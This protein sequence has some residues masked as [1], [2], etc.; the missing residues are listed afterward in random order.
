M[1]GTQF[2]PGGHSV[3]WRADQT[4]LYSPRS[5]PCYIHFM[6]EPS[7]Q[8]QSFGPQAD[9]IAK[10][11]L[12]S[13]DVHEA[14]SARNTR[15]TAPL[16]MDD[17][18]TPAWADP[19]MIMKDTIK[20]ET[21]RAPSSV[22][23]STSDTCICEDLHSRGVIVLAAVYG[24]ITIRK[25]DGALDVRL[26]VRNKVYETLAFYFSMTCPLDWLGSWVDGTNTFPSDPAYKSL[27]K[28]LSKEMK[29]RKRTDS[30]TL[31]TSEKLFLQDF[32]A[33]DA[34][35][36]DL[37]LSQVSPFFLSVATAR[38]SFSEETV[39]SLEGDYRSSWDRILAIA[40]SKPGDALGCSNLSDCPVALPK[41]S[42]KTVPDWCELFAL[43][44]DVLLD[45]GNARGS[46]G[47]PRCMG[48]FT[49]AA[50][51]LVD[52]HHNGESAFPLRQHPDM[53]DSFIS[54]T[55][56]VTGDAE[57]GGHFTPEGPFFSPINNS[58]SDDSVTTLAVLHRQSSQTKDQVL[59]Q[60]CLCMVSLLS[61]LRSAGLS[62][63]PVFGVVIDQ[64][65]CTLLA[66]MQ[67]EE[68]ASCSY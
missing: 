2:V 49:D 54:A 13:V 65:E 67:D 17:G 1:S 25:F 22:L 16:R 44:L 41:I 42:N 53:N 37:F 18:Q 9:I 57:H 59:D 39:P 36:F 51:H 52:F 26:R 35:G 40:C 60:C 31:S 68:T 11:A 43:H 4:T 62:G 21:L 29:A 61:S 7:D 56:L 28:K 46:D 12:S 50:F 32:Q 10:S 5:N 66:A 19:S 55:L 33:D 63:T 48:Y 30:A 15:S 34:I 3:S 24:E 23:S 45:H 58:T 38:S 20:E 47:P 14:D 64:T 6:K 27:Q 8:V